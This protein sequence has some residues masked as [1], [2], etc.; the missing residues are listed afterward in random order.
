VRVNGTTAILVTAMVCLVWSATN[1]QD[2][3]E[4]LRAI[5]HERLK[6]L[7]DADIDTANRLHADDFQLVNPAGATLA[8]KEYIGQIASGELDYLVWEPGVID[9]R[10]YGA[11]AVIRY[12]ARAQATVG[13]RTTP[14]RSFWH[15]DVYEK[16]NDRWQAVWSQATLIQ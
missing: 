3:S 11:A 13:G 5:E 12:Q 10:L 7:V 4:Q 16:R 14:L 8:K 6:A 1:G 9:V 2:E 15:T